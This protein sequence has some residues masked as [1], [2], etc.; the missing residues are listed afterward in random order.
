M[1]P[2]LFFLLICAAQAQE[3]RGVAEARRELER[4]QWLVEAGNLPPS[5]AAEAREN[6]NDAIDD[7]VLSGVFAA[8]VRAELFTE[9]QGSDLLDA[10]ER[11]VARARAKLARMDELIANDTAPKGSR[12][13][14]EAEWNSRGETL[15]RAKD[16]VSLLSQI[17]AMARAELHPAEE[18]TAGAHLMA[19]DELRALAFSYERKFGEALPISANGVTA[20]H[21]AM[22]LDHTGRIDVAVMPDSP[23]GRWLRE[24]L[25]NRA[26]PYFAFRTAVPGK[27]TAPHIH[28]GPAST[29]L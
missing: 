16:L 4:V 3:S 18:K 25:S 28:I 27:A 2:V 11:R 7:D 21:K 14:L 6:L 15:A 29:R 20:V 12:G 22:G 9:K 19:P 8:P 13:P 23:E 24:Y 17:A 10:A 1:K 26:I 5:K